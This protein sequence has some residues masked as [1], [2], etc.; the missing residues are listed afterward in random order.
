MTRD[1]I[2]TVLAEMSINASVACPD[3]GG[4]LELTEA[5][6]MVR[7]ASAHNRIDRPLPTKPVDVIALACS[8]CEFIEDVRL[9]VQA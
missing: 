4:Q 1:A 7:V 9:A 3:C 8:G 2:R 5:T 6:K